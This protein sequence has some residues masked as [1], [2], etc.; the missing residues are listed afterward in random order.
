[1]GAFTPELSVNNLR[2]GLARWD[3]LAR[4]GNWP[5]DL[6]ASMYSSDVVALSAGLSEEWWAAIV[7]RLSRWRAI[8][9]LRNQVV[10]QAGLVALPEMTQSYE[11]LAA[12]RLQLENVAWQDVSML[13]AT[14]AGLK[15]TRSN[16]PVFGSKLCH[17]MLPRLYPVIDRAAV[18]WDVP[19]ERYWSACRDAWLRSVADHDELK[20]IINLRVPDA[21]RSAF[22]YATKIP[23]LCIAGERTGRA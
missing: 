23:E 6:H 12:R 8:R 1:M 10:L 15:P 21:D 20:A 9:P 17:F 19:Y 5:E 18:G 4:R 2:R 11:A 14:A 16:S 22:P 3:E 7:R 13:Y